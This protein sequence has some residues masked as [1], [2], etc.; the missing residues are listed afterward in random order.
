[1]SKRKNNQSKLDEEMVS[2]GR[3]R[4]YH[5]V[6]RASETSL[7]ST[8]S[9]GQYLL[10]E[11]IESLTETLK[12]W[13]HNARRSPGRRHRAYP[14]LEQL[15]ANVVAGLTAR[16]IL[17]CISI[18]RKITST[19]T[20]I[21]RLLEDECKFRQLKRDEPALWN[22]MNRVL[23]R[24]K[25]NKTKSKFINNTA[26]FHEIVLP[27]WDRKVAAAVGLTCIELMR[28]ATGIIEIL[29]RTDINGKSYT[30]IRPTDA[31]LRW[32]KNTHEYNE[33]LNP[34]WLP[35]VEKPIPW[36]N[37]YIGGYQSTSHR[38]RP[39]IKTTDASYLEEVSL[40]DM[41]EVYSAV[42]TV[43]GTP[44]LVDGQLLDLLKHCWDKSLPIGGL[45]SME[46][47]PPPPKPADIATNKESR[48]SWRKSAARVHFENERQKSKRL[49]V[50][51]VI[52]LGDK[53]I[54]DTIYFPHSF[55]FRGRG[56]PI[57]YFL[58]PQGPEWSQSLLRFGD[59]SPLTDDGVKWLYINAANKW[60]L[61][62]APYSERLKW[63][64]GNMELIRRIGN[65]PLSDM[66]WADADEPWTF[67]SA[68]M[69]IDR[70]H[71]HGEGFISRLPIA[72]D[73]TNQGLQIYSMLLR[74]P[75]AAHSTNVLPTERPEDVYQDVADIVRKKLYQDHNA[76]GK[77][78]LDFGITRKTTKRQ[79]MTVCYSSTFYSCRMYTT[80]WF[81][82]ELKKGKDNPF[83][84]ETYRPCNYLAEVIW[85]SISEVVASA[86]AGMDWLKQCATVCL[87]YGVTPRWLTP[88]GFP[89]KMHYENTDKYTIKTLVSGVLRQH[90]LRIPNGDPNR[91]KTLNGICPNY[92]HSLDGFGGLLG[93]TVN[94]ASAAGIRSIMEVHD[95][96]K[97]TASEVDTMHY[98]VRSATVD[99]FS[100]NLLENFA[101]Q[102]TLLL[103]S[104][105]SLPSI[106]ELGSLDIND[107]RRSEYY[108]N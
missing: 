55:D 105:I 86:R 102:L 89:V 42:N 39:L 25:S 56:Y 35:M 91:R 72:M 50:M 44:Y 40:T 78:W 13:L 67:V 31:L 11:A 107:V 17:D 10:G 103:P 47:D 71:S 69:E 6:K 81:Y 54:N 92:V 106:P 94:R 90:R 48:R 43:Q 74:D 3:E 45:P 97:V 66:T 88:L 41:S 57:P 83:G 98:C 99:I 60:G 20:I 26:R 51:K 29:T 95:S 96:L 15:P 59:G 75:V 62:K 21:G 33:A 79:T 4:Y 65:D 2:L 5:K 70:M 76:Y 80:E 18:E 27:T 63:S 14:Y 53:F 73:A 85:E 82:E 108:F 7:E 1:V 104:G 16:C 87:E 100:V 101:E 8:T 9:V 36:N 93:G 34:V 37:P 23:D 32:I 30:Y 49:Q 24:F 46:D 28:Q 12:D 38:R 58:Q 64:E 68:C 77:K 52:N 22:Q 84:V 61:D 19:A